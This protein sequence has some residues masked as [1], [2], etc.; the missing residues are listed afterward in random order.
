MLDLAIAYRIYPGVSKVPAVFADDKLKLSILC[1]ESFKRALGHLR[2]KMWVLLDGC[3]P[4]YEDLFRVYFSK[5]ELEI[6]HLDKIGN[7]P[8]FA[9]QIE[10]LAEQTEA[11]LV[12]F[13]EDD[14]FYLPE[15]LVKMVAFARGNSDAD[16]ITPY[17][18]PGNYDPS[19][20]TEGHLIRPF[21]DR[22]WRT[23]TATCLTFLAKREALIR[24]RHI[25]ETYCNKNTD[26]SL[27]LS[28]T[29][30]ESLLNPRLHWRDSDKFKHWLMAWFYGYGQI[31]FGAQRKLW[32]AIP[33]VATHIESPCLAPVVDWHAEFNHAQEDVLKMASQLR[34]E[35][36]KR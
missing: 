8:T 23:A 13:A 11:D 30:K 17:D 1:L 2:I 22:H 4:V 21:G 18:H 28:L 27:W 5:K 20:G 7:L 32:H 3:P 14:Y 6:I 12:Y 24:T 15:A 36:S 29:Q 34:R 9:M 10:I 26:A 19:L 35:P 31:L 33:S 16:F 25:F